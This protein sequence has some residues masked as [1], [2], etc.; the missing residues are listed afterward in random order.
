MGCFK[1]FDSLLREAGI[2]VTDE[3]I[4]EIN[5]VI[6]Q[7]LNKQANYGDCSAEWRR[8]RKEIQANEQMRQKLIKELRIL[9]LK[10]IRYKDF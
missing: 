1:W 3:N 9:Y 5:N 4:A 8:A 2:E 7:F 6:H 10:W